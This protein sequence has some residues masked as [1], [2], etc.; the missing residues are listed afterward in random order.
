MKIS[1][2][3]LLV[4]YATAMPNPSSN[5]FLIKDSIAVPSGWVQGNAPVDLE[6][7]VDFGFGL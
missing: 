2:I 7:T 4:A 6:Q 3:T 1:T 5:S